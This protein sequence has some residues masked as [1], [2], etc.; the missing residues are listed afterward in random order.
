M[1]IDDQH[2]QPATAEIASI[3]RD[4]LRTHF[5][6]RLRNEDA[7]LLTRGGAKGLQIYEE[8]KRDGQAGAVLAKR[9]LAVTSRAWVVEPASKAAQDVA[10]A[11]LVRSAL[12]HIKFNRLCKR[13]LD[14]TLKG[15]SVA[16]VM[17]EVRDGQWLPARVV[18]RDPRRFLFRVDGE[19]RLLTRQ[20]ILEG[21]PLPDRK[22]IVHRYGGDDDTP[23]GLGLGSALFWPVFFKKQGISFWL[24]FADKFGSPT[25]VG[26][27]QA[28]AGKP[29]QQRLLA[30]L[31][32]L[33][34]DAGV[35]I[36]E[37]M[38]IEFLEAQRSG[39]VDTYERLCRYMDELISKIVLGETMSTTSAPAG[40]GSSQANVHNDVRLEVAQDD[41]DELAETLQ[42]SVIR[43]IVEYNLGDGVGMPKLRR[44]F[45]EPE[46]LAARATRDKTLS[47]MGWEPTPE[48]ML[49]TYGPGWI[50]K[51]P[52]PNPMAALMG[53]P[54]SEPAAEDTPTES[55]ASTAGN[56]SGDAEDEDEAGA[57]AEGK[58]LQA[59]AR[60]RDAHRAAQQ[61]L[62]DAAAQLAG[63]WRQLVGPQLQ[64]LMATFEESRDLVAFREGLT[65]LANKPPSTEAVEAIARATFAANVVGRGQAKKPQQGLLQTLLNRALG[66]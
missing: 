48:Y 54:G 42:D 19:L 12:E 15:Y 4:H 31:A 26:K 40:L 17:W 39:S 34:Q 45:A 62:R 5:G 41:S 51:A 63:Q 37:G 30:A 8:I 44:E 60:Q 25:A 57:F 49:E 9:K 46:D 35:I 28:N 55:S 52:A 47:D 43:W 6:Q 3:E 65:R 29:E 33:A 16:E 64:E 18:A 23:Y 61:E 10:A 56:R 66:R 7:T 24:T 20:A 11:D 50:K 21:E 32:A 58:P 53:L 22:F 59:A 2:G 36:P 14:A 13:L 1:A 27:Y 38:A